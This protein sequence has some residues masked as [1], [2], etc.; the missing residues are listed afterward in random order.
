VI[1]PPRAARRTV[2]LGLG[3][4]A[5]RRILVGSCSVFGNTVFVYQFIT[6]ISHRTPH[7]VIVTTHRSAP[8]EMQSDSRL[9]FPRREIELDEDSDDAYREISD[10][11]LSMITPREA[12]CQDIDDP[13]MSDWIAKNLPDGASILDAGCGLGFHIVALKMGIPAR[14]TGKTFEVYGADYSAAMLGIARSRG[15]HAGI[16]DNCY[17][18]S[19]FAGLSRIGEWESAF[20][21]VLVNYALYSYPNSIAYGEYDDYFLESIA[22]VRHVLRSDGQFLF[23]TRDW[24]SFVHGSSAVHVHA[25]THSGTTYKCEYRWTFG[26]DGAHRVGVTMTNA[27]SK[28]QQNTVLNFAERTPVQLARLLEKGGFRVNSVAAH[29]TS[30]LKFNTL[31]TSLS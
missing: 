31:L 8:E 2:A 6:H 17:R 3:G 4:E 29:G 27:L 1:P 19:S 16:A 23:N 10:L 28:R 7:G 30:T 22:G 26:R 9:M 13:V 14:H 11:Y 15:A 5:R 25:N 20:N 12:E 21:C 18:Q 24:D